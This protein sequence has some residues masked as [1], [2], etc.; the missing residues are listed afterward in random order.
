MSLRHHMLRHFTGIAPQYREL[1]TTD[2]APIGLIAERLARPSRVR[3]A[4]IG[5]G[6]GRYDLLLFEHLPGLHLIGVDVNQAMLSQA[7][8]LLGA[9]GIDSFEPLRASLEELALETDSL[10]FVCSFNAIHHFDVPTFLAKAGAALKKG[11]HVFIYTR[12]PDQ[13]ERSV[14]GRHFPGFAEKE[15]RL[16]ELGDMRRWIEGCDGLRFQEPTPFRHERTASL[17]RLLDQARGRHYSTLSLY[18]EAEFEDAL[19]LFEKRLRRHFDDL[20]RIEWCDENILFEARRLD[21]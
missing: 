6:D 18:S 9:D 10:D 16:Y 8:E 5:C 19:G 20:E 14:W 17:E 3:G 11:G 4:D 2:A 15:T 13:N 21:S 1:R 7:V 12:L